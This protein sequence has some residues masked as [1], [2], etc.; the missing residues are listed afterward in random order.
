MTEPETDVW[1]WW[2]STSLDEG[3]YRGPFATSELALSN[4][5]L[6]VTGAAHGIW[7]FEGKRLPLR[8]ALFDADKVLDD[9]HVL[10]EE[11]ADADG[12]LF[13][14]PSGA[15]KL[16][17]TEALNAIWRTWRRRHGLGRAFGIETR[18]ENPV[19]LTPPEP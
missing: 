19:Q 5:R 1:Q 14:D 18:N 8:D 6:D 15:Q 16:E 2:W 4:A 3:R 10:N 7:L 17:L 9:W 12:G 11:V 13:M